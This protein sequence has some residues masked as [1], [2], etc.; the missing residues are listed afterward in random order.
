MKGATGSKSTQPNPSAIVKKGAARFEPALTTPSS[1]EVGSAVGQGPTVDGDRCYAALLARDARFDGR[2]FTAVHTT[3]IY[4][5][6]ICPA[7]TP[8][9][10]NVTFYLC[11]AAAEA[12][13]FRPCL[14]CRPDS[15]PG[16]PEWRGTSSSV[17]RALRLIDEGTL[18]DGGVPRLAERLGI[19]ER[20]LHRLFLKHLGASPVAVGQSRRAHMARQLLETSRSTVAEIAFASG[21]GSVRR[22]NDVF[23]RTFG[24]TPSELRG[25]AV[26]S[27]L[28]THLRIRVRPPYDWNTLTA[29][30]EPRCLPGIESVSEGRYVRNV[31]TP[32]GERGRIEVSFDEKQH[33]LEVATDLSPSLSLMGWMSRV[34]DL[35]DTQTETEAVEAHLRGT[36]YDRLFRLGRGVRV[37]GAWNGFELAVRAILGQQITVAGATTLARRLIERCGG[38]LRPEAVAEADLTA[39]GMP[40]KRVE[41][42]QRLAAHVAAG[43]I[44]LEPWTDPEE[45]RMRLAEIPGIG[46]WTVEYIALRALRDPDAFPASDLGLRKA[47]GNGTALP[48]KEVE[49]IAEAWRP[50]RAYAAQHLWLSLE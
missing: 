48:T 18:E 36:E 23:R 11:P 28:G 17:S 37:H 43:E 8:K 26:E 46:P 21:F 5:R 49:R 16:S 42:L 15:A 9:K 20:H 47:L 34:Q 10:Q 2:F 6:P 27:P 35:F 24:R 40:T 44:V 1:S 45:T 4:C 39:F 41:T 38:S 25:P 14:R 19:G 7:K 32:E 22:F 13:G 33:C 50:W 30:L 31:Q 3:G 12:A 29:F